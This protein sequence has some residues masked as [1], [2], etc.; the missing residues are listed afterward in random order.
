M[1]KVV[2]KPIA[3]VPNSPIQQMPRLTYQP[4]PK[5]TW[6]RHNELETKKMNELLQDFAPMPYERRMA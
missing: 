3:R 2:R 5:T 1:F 6:A 4:L